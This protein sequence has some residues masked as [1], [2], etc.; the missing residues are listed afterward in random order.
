MS[1]TKLTQV[2]L[3][4]ADGAQITIDR[5]VADRSILLKNM[6]E[7]LGE[8]S[9]HSTPVPLPNVRAFP[10]PLYPANLRADSIF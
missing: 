3:A 7:D 6:I 5:A 4:S 9:V 10:A 8:D 2:I 1:D